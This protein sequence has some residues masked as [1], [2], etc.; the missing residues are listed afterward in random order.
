[1]IYVILIDGEPH[2]AEQGRIRT[3]K[4]EASAIREIRRLQRYKYFWSRK[5]ETAVF[6]TLF[7]KEVTV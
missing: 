4:T 1:M 3:Y 2:T 7:A 6:T 5:L